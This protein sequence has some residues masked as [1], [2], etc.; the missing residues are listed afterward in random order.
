ML[1]E[2][3]QTLKAYLKAFRNALLPG[4]LLGSA[5]HFFISLIEMAYMHDGLTHSTYLMVL[6]NLRLLGLPGFYLPQL[7]G[8]VPYYWTPHSRGTTFW[9]DLLAYLSANIVGWTVIVAAVGYVGRATLEKWSR[10][11]SRGR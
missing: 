6:R 8:I 11:T 5:E 3:D 7:F 2:E 4:T 10:R 9:I 1:H